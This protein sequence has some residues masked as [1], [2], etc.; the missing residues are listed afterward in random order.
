[1]NRYEQITYK[2]HHINI[3]YDD[4]PESPREWSNLGTFYTAHRRYRPEKEFDEHFDFDEVCDGHPGNIR[5]SFLQKHVALNLFLYDHSGLSI[6]SGPFSCRWDS[7]WF[8]IVAVSVE[9]VKKEYGWK[10]LTQSRRK[11]IEEYL[12]NEIDTYNEYLHGEVYGFQ[13]TPEDDDTEKHIAHI[14]RNGALQV[15]LERHVARHGL[16]V[17]VESQTD[18]LAFGVEHR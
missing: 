18:Q 14:D 3:Y 15:G 5:K 4:C 9:Q 7:G 10:V 8:G 11:K 6:S 17:A 16:P 12:Q 2:G 1:M 13:V